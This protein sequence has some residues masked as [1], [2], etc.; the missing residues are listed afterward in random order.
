MGSIQVYLGAGTCIPILPY[1]HT[2]IVWLKTINLYFTFKWNQEIKCCLPYND[3]NI[4]YMSGDEIG[5]DFVNL[6]ENNWWFFYSYVS[7]DIYYDYNE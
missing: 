5:Y 2:L 7:R 4:C 6:T 1:E 3:L